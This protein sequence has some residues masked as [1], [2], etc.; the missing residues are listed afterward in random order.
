MN[1]PFAHLYI[2]ALEIKFEDATGRQDRS[3]LES[4]LFE[5][6]FRDRPKA[7]ALKQKV[8]LALAELPT[9]SPGKPTEGVDKVDPTVETPE[10]TPRPPGREETEPPKAEEEAEESGYEDLPPPKRPFPSGERRSPSG[11][12]PSPVVAS[13]QVIDSE[14]AGRVVSA[15]IALEVLSP[16]TFRYPTDLVDGDRR[17]IADFSKLDTLLPWE[18][19]EKAIPVQPNLARRPARLSYPGPGAGRS[20]PT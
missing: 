2:T 8:V 7:K 11:K 1:R 9:T 13:H 10:E 5:L 16:Q 6:G 17:R 4:L 3:V 14:T 18:R 20:I 19:G 15:W 12:R